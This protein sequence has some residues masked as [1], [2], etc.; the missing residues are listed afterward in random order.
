MKK[1]IVLFI[2]A[3][4]AVILYGC[5][6]QTYTITFDT[7]GG[8]IIEPLPVTAGESYS[9]PVPEKSGYQFTGWHTEQDTLFT[10]DRVI[11]SDL[12]LFASWEPMEFT[13]SFYTYDN[14][15]LSEVKVKTG[16]TVQTPTAP[17]RDG[18]T[19]EKWDQ[20]L[21]E[22]ASDLSVKAIYTLN[23][24]T[25]TFLDFDG[26]VLE[27]QH[28]KYKKN[29]SEP[30]Q[31]VREGYAFA[32]W[33]VPFYQI[34]SD[35]TV[36][37]L[38]EPATDGLEF[39]LT[40]NGYTVAGYHGSSREVIIPRIYNGQPVTKIS[41]SAFYNAW[42]LTKVVI[43]DSV[44][45]IGKN[46]FSGD[47]YLTD[48]T[49]PDSIVLIDDSAFSGCTRLQSI[50]IPA[51][52]IGDSAFNNCTQ[53]TNI[54]LTDHVETIGVVAFQG[55]NNLEEIYIPA[56]VSSIGK[57]AFSWMKNLHY[58]YTPSANVERLTAMLAESDSIYT[59]YTIVAKD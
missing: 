41:D 58:I 40:A 24:Y 2:M 32:G 45:V 33:D 1:P 49:I 39:E 27:V 25:V 48:V 54:I 6:K 30:E 50:V 44:T 10:E 52:K 42:N 15:L 17:L 56:S 14:K 26:T 13:V 5:Q 28:V 37:A 19:F 8:S 53:L 29:A 55:A 43:P 34:T 38:Y 36:T 46:A 18:Y 7:E 21:T 16:E 20:N 31:P 23:T 47:D 22:I 35:L 57:N 3:L 9:L 4:L 51:K 11:D 59:S 12:I